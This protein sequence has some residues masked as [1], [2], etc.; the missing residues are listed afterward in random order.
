MNWRDLDNFLNEQCCLLQDIGFPGLWELAPSLEFLPETLSQLDHAHEAPVT[1]AAEALA[2]GLPLPKLEAVGRALLYMR[3]NFAQHLC[4]AL[5]P[6]QEM[7]LVAPPKGSREAL[8]YWLLIEA[9]I[10]SGH[11]AIHGMA[12]SLRRDEPTCRCESWVN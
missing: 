7:G 11:A 8:L 4:Q 10:D 2:K 1:R 5:I 3:L 9:W 6:A 12:V